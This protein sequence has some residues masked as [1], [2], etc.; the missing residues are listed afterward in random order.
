MFTVGQ[1]MIPQNVGHCKPTTG[2][3]VVHR[4]IIGSTTTAIKRGFI[5][6]NA[7]SFNSISGYS[8][9]KFII[10]AIPL[11]MAAPAFS[12]TVYFIRH[13]EKPSSGNG[14]SS[15]GEE[16]AQCLRNVFGASSSYQID[17]IMAQMPQSGWYFRLCEIG[18]DD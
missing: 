5:R 11:L 3:E 13:G 6:D 9:M 16:R 10:A 8:N 17:Y 2:C 12:T 7:L 18:T 15:Q 4:R 14:L 1:T